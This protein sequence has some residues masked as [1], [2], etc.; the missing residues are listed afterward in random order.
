MQI[1]RHL[2]LIV[3]LLMIFINAKEVKDESFEFPELL[4]SSDIEYFSKSFDIEGLFWALENTFLQSDRNTEKNRVKHRSLS[5]QLVARGGGDT[6]TAE[7]KL[8][9]DL[10]QAQ[11]LA[12]VL[13]TLDPQ[14]ANLLKQK[15]IPAY[16]LVLDR[17]PPVTELEKFH[18][19]YPFTKS[20]L[21]IIHHVYNQ[22][23]H[24]TN[25]PQ[26]DHDLLSDSFDAVVIQNEWASLVKNGQPGIVTIDNL[27]SKEA[28][29]KIQNL[30]WESTVWYQTKMP[31]KFGGYVG[32][33]ID[34]GLYD[35]ILLQLAFELNQKLPL[36]MK[37]HYM[38][39]LWAYK[40][41]STIASGINIHADQAAVNVNIWLTPEDANLDKTNGGLV[42]FTTKPPPDWDFLQYNTDTAK[43]VKEILEPTGFANV[44]IPYRENRAV[45]FDSALF[46]HTDEFHFREGYKNHRINLT[47]LYGDMNHESNVGGSLEQEEKVS[48]SEL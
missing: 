20:D 8:K 2:P 40:Y 28:L 10:E 6:Y 13:Q 39:Y 1:Q 3:S 21:E 24:L 31:L 9:M 34:D 12:E 38:K 47:I 11:Y 29:S 7:Y 33:Y 18:G 43:V 16:K 17:I 25:V 27:L 46:H 45:I 44:T 26:Q 22:A 5:Q 42:I 14:K 30:L 35:K 48:H 23:W 19:L 37:N 4:D 36:I 41:D 32:A 15:V